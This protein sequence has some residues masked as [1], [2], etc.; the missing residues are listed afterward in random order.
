VGDESFTYFDP[1]LDKV[2]AREHA[3]GA[4]INFGFFPP[5]SETF[6]VLAAEWQ[7][8]YKASPAATSCRNSTDPVLA[9]VT[10]SLAAPASE[11]RHLLSAEMRG[12]LPKPAVGLSLRVAHDLRNDRTEVDLPVYLLK[13]V[14]GQLTGGL[15]LGWTSEEHFNLGV[16]VGVPLSPL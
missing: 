11:V 7:D 12:Y 10:G 6:F 4:G 9:C 3:W 8:G 13:S 14:D 16:F 15:R 1:A 2:K 5:G